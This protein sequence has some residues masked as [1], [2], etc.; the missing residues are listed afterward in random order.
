MGCLG[1][2]VPLVW[3]WVFFLHGGFIHPALVV[4]AAGEARSFMA[5]LEHKRFLDGAASICLDRVPAWLQKVR[6]VNEPLKNRD[7]NFGGHFLSQNK[8]QAAKMGYIW[9]PLCVDNQFRPSLKK[10]SSQ[11][12]SLEP[13]DSLPPVWPLAPPIWPNLPDHIFI[14]ISD[15]AVQ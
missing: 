14:C 13:S 2:H 12:F 11:N 5:D 10:I 3:D 8:V 4:H 9:N 7:F 1:E 15:G 6:R